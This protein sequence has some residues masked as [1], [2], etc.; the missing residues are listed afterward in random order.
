MMTWSKGAVIKGQLVWMEPM[1]VGH[2]GKWRRWQK[3]DNCQHAVIE[4][5]CIM[6][7]LKSWMYNMQMVPPSPNLSLSSHPYPYTPSNFLSFIFLFLSLVTALFYSC[8]LKQNSIFLHYNLPHLSL[9]RHSF[10]IHPLFSTLFHPIRGTSCV[11]NYL[12]LLTPVPH[13]HHCTPV[14]PFFACHYIHS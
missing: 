8:N 10:E 9:Q 6:V 7:R 13:N 3:T 2:S 14:S 4:K 1:E 11:T 5:T 12:F